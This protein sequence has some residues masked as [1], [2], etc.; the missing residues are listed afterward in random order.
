MD[1][2]RFEEVGHVELPMLLF[3]EGQATTRMRALGAQCDAKREFDG[4]VYC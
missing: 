2:P 3:W 1:W 4:R